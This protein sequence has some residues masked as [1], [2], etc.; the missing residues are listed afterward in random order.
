MSL[1]DGNE[2]I[3]QRGPESDAQRWSETL[4]SNL[5]WVRIADIGETE[6][7]EVEQGVEVHAGDE[8]NEECHADDILPLE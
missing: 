4:Q 2:R 8:G 1:A 7:D 3:A 5:H 6:R